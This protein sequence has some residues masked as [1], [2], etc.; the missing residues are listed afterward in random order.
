[1]PR[2]RREAAIEGWR[3][4]ERCY[5]NTIQYKYTNTI[6]HILK[7]IINVYVYSRVHTIFIILVC[8]WM[9]IGGWWMKYKCSSYSRTVSNLSS[10][11]LLVA[12]SHKIKLIDFFELIHSVISIFSCYILVYV[13]LNCSRYKDGSQLQSRSRLFCRLSPVYC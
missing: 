9:S 6:Q 2:I 7:N 10:Q 8:V 4:I 5:Y 12:V 11:L 3:Y 1:M 13:P